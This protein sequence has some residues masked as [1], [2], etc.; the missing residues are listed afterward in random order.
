MYNSRLPEFGKSPVTLL[1]TENCT[2]S[3]TGK[4][5]TSHWVN[6]AYWNLVELIYVVKFF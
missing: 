4:V 2:A 3:Q 1:I 5:I 6:A